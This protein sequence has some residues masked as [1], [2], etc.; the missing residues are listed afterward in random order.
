MENNLLDDLA[1]LNKEAPKL[2][3]VGFVKRLLA[4][5]LD[6]FVISGMTFVFSML[7]NLIDLIFGGNLNMLLVEM[8][9]I[10]GMV[11]YAALMESSKYQATLGKQ[12]L[13]IKVVGK[14][15]ERILFGQAVLRFGLKFL[16][17]II[18][19][20]GFLMIAFTQKNQGLHDIITDTF[21]VENN[22][23]YN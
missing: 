16:S 3:Y 12:A 19:F 8:L 11:L 2:V 13:G 6:L 1:Y 22:T 18:F 17:Y 20:I 23:R 5:I 7:L 21:V 15:G 14:N 9:I 10:P 4:A